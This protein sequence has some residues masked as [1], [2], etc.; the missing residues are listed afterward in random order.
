ME[1]I[2]SGCFRGLICGSLR[3]LLSV[4][5]VGISRPADVCGLRIGSAEGVFGVSHPGVLVDIISLYFST[6]SSLH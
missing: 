6:A 3:C 1:T 2:F 5:I 4:F